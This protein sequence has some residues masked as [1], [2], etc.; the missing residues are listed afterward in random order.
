M[1]AAGYSD[2]GFV[3]KTFPV[4]V[5]RF[6]VVRLAAARLC[7]YQGVAGVADYA[8]VGFVVIVGRWLLAPAS[9]PAV[10]CLAAVDSAP[11][12]VVQCLLVRVVVLFSAVCFLFSVSVGLC[13]PAFL[14]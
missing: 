6:F 3:A 14:N 4:A 9:Y 10:A 13:S 1:A 7:G 8:V 5:G 2:Y 11:H 12:R